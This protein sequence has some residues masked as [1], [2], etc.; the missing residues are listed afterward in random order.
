MRKL[1]LILLLTA[2]TILLHGCSSSG[3]TGIAMNT[4]PQQAATRDEKL[5]N[6]DTKHSP[7]EETESVGV[8]PVTQHDAPVSFS[9]DSGF[10][11]APFE[12]SITAPEDCRIYY[13]LDGSLPDESSTEFKPDETLSVYDRSM[14]PNDISMIEGTTTGQFYAPTLLIDKATILRAVAYNSE[15]PISKV[16]TKTYFVGYGDKAEY[17]K[18]VAVISLV[19]APEYLFDYDTG[20]YVTGATFDNWRTGKDYNPTTRYW[21][22][23]AN[24]K[25]SGMEWERPAHID[26]FEE[27]GVLGFSEDIG[28]R[29][30]G[31]ASRAFLQKSF[32]LYA[33]GKYGSKSFRYSLFPGL[34]SQYDGS[35]I[36][37]FD[38]LML[39]NGGNDTELTKIREV[40]IH[41]LSAELDFCVQASRPAVVFL[42]GEYWGLYNLQEKYS[43]DYIESHYGVDKE[44]VIIIKTDQVDEGEETDIVYYEALFDYALKHDLSDPKEYEHFSSMLDIEGF[45]DYVCT[46]VYV[47]NVDWGTNNVMLWR[48]R[49]VCTDGSNPYED[50]RWRFMLYDTEYSTGLSYENS[51]AFDARYNPSVVYENSFNRAMNPGSTVGKLFSSLLAN[52]GFRRQFKVRFRELADTIFHKDH[53][54]PLLEQYAAT[55]RP[56]MADTLMRYRSI[57]KEGALQQ[58]DYEVKKIRNYFNLRYDIILEA[59]NSTIPD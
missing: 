55:Y 53:V 5:T 9:A 2:T 31:G 14:D 52:D 30:R 27:N 1:S 25:N 46:E 17:Y 18:D 39:R 13:T 19:T 28:I 44:N 36:D 7:A 48:S 16:I 54:L 11:D 47:G 6:K 58:F 4:D 29:L 33:R 35:K 34:T 15:G 21:H 49:T 8:T 12:L 23:P 43:E 41:Q 57:T 37:K 32:N 10:Y 26:F 22:Q 42:N 24:Y 50:G 51:L 40:M 3:E 45:I 20:I 56:M 59:L 38:S